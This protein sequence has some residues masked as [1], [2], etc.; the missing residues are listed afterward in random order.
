MTHA[1]KVETKERIME[2]ASELFSIYGYVGTSV[3]EIAAKSNVNIASI[4]Y[5]FGNKHN[6]YWAT[7]DRKQKWLDEGIRQLSETTEDVAELTVKAYQFLMQDQAAVR[8]TLKMLLTDGVPDPEGALREEMMSTMGPPGTQ[9]FAKVIS[10][11]ISKD[12]S[13]ETVMWGVKC[14][15]SALVHWAMMCSSC[16]FELMKQK[17]PE[18]N[19]E[20]VEK[21][22]YHH[23]RAIMTYME[24]EKPFGTTSYTDLA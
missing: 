22:L 7:V 20:S 1:E 2:V 4:N 15:F 23:T 13:S 8:T 9:H 18:L 17:M 11:Q 5:H 10:R 21:I 19:G 12:V 24:S 3:R 16:K 6:L 14:I